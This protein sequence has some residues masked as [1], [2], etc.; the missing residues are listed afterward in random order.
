VEV[1]PDGQ[2]E[3]PF[4][5]VAGA[6]GQGELGPHGTEPA[7]VGYGEHRVAGVFGQLIVYLSADIQGLL[8]DGRR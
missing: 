4:D 8:A 1:Q 6:G 3:D 5:G 7:A 2:I